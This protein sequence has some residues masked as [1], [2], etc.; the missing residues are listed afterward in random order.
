MKKVQ[1]GINGLSRGKGDPSRDGSISDLK[2]G[3]L[4]EVKEWGWNA[5]NLADNLIAIDYETIEGLRS[6][7]E[8]TIET[9][10][11]IRFSYS[12]TWGI[13]YSKPKEIEGYWSYV[14]LFPE[15]FDRLMS[16]I[17]LEGDITKEMIPPIHEKGRFDIYLTTL[18]LKEK[19]R[20]NGV[21][22][23][24]YDSFIRAVE[25]LAKSGVY[26]DRIGANAYTLAGLAVCTRVFGMKYLRDSPSSGK[27]MGGKFYPFVPNGIAS[28]SKDLE[29][30]YDKEF[31][32]RR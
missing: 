7:D 13:I 24:L 8:G 32:N 2:V 4:S 1:K 16:G 26:F 30:I 10:K 23:L 9:W 19:H 6:E 22:H 25:E 12:Q 14:P 15:Y 21:V 5:E 20:G 3:G 17:I 31:R 28:K 29:S 11:D 27:I 18:A